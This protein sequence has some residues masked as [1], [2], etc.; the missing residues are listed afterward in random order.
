MPRYTLYDLEGELNGTLLEVEFSCIGYDV[1]YLGLGFSVENGL[2]DFSIYEAD[3][4]RMCIKASAK[5]I[6]LID[7]TKF[8][9]SSISSYASIDDLNLVITDSGLSENTKE[10]YEKAGVDLLIAD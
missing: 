2:T 7:H 4:K 6:A 10:I 8:D 5:T 3:L 1:E 9:T